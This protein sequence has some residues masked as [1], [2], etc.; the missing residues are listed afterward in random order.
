VLWGLFLL[1]VILIYARNRGN[2]NVIAK[3]N[4]SGR[5]VGEVSG[6]AAEHK[7]DNRDETKLCLQGDH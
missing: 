6:D 4:A 1:G 2:Y 7:L 5:V 3:D